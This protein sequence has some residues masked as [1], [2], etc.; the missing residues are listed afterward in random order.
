MA[1]FGALHGISALLFVI[2][3]ISAIVAAWQFTRRAA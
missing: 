2:A 3:C 1:R